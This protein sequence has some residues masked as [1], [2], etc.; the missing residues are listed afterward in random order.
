MSYKLTYLDNKISF[1]ILS[2]FKKHADA[3]EAEISLC[4]V[5]VTKIPILLTLQ[6]TKQF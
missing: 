2:T 4:N 6:S 3:P 5:D 1:S